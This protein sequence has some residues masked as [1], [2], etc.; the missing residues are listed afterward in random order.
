LGE[1]LG[2]VA[3]GPLTNIPPSPGN[4]RLT[5]LNSQARG[6]AARPGLG[7]LGLLR[8][9]PDLVRHPGAEIAVF[10]LRLVRLHKRDAGPAVRNAV[11]IEKPSG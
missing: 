8:G 4:V 6:A 10:G 3:Y 2:H 1:N 9:L 11:A 7:G 5:L